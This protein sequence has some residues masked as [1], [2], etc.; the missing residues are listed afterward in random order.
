MDCLVAKQVGLVAHKPTQ[1]KPA[2]FWLLGSSVG[3]CQA[4]TVAPIAATEQQPTPE[5]Q[6][7]MDRMVQEQS[8]QLLKQTE[9]KDPS[10]RSSAIG[11]LGSVGVKDDPNVDAAIRDAL[12]DED[13]NVRS[14]AIASIVQRGGDDVNDQ[15]SRALKDKAA[16]VR[17]A[18]VS[19]ITDDVALLN[20]AV[21]DSDQSVREIAKSMLENLQN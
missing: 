9:S 7:E 3:S 5:A 10:E 1:D 6:A 16:I 19:A 15:I 4:V 13:A 2:E 14:Q 20:Q 8:D 17:I 12:G 11:N 21:N 18:A